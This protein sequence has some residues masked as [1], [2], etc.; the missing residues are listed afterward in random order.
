MVIEQKAK[1]NTGY[2]YAL[3]SFAYCNRDIKPVIAW[4]KL[5]KIIMGLANR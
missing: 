1:L 5:R 2:N 4:N 3:Y